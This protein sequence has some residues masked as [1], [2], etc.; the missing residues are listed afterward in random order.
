MTQFEAAS[1][2]LQETTNAQTFWIGL[3]QIVVILLG[4]ATMR[5]KGHARAQEHADHDTK[6]VTTPRTLLEWIIPP[7]GSKKWK[8]YDVPGRSL[9]LHIHMSAKLR[10]LDMRDQGVIRTMN[11]DAPV[12][13]IAES[14]WNRISQK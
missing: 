1:L 6:T 12:A 2:A 14:T 13:K 9:Q 7:K 4:L 3:G 11:G 8:D 10:G 5:W